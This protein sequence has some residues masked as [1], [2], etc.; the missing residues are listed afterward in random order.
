MDERILFEK[1]QIENRDKTHK[2]LGSALAFNF[3]GGVV[4][5]EK[6]SDAWIL[7]GIRNVL[8][9]HIKIRNCG[10]LLHRVS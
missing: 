2:T 6:I 9:N 4:G 1:D 7:Q 8:G 3:F 10:S 5:F